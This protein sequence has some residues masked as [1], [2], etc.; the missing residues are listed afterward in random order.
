MLIVTIIVCILTIV[1]W[2][3]IQKKLVKRKI[4]KDK[5]HNKVVSKAER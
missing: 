4:Y 3:L 5:K 1:A 2:G